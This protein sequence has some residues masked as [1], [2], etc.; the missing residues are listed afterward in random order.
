MSTLQT[1]LVFGG[2]VKVSVADTVEIVQK[3][4]NLHNMS[5]TATAALGRTL[6]AAV[7]LSSELKGNGEKM[8][9]TVDGKGKLGKIVVAAMAGGFVRGYVE[10]PSVELPLNEKGKLAVGEAVGNDGFITIIKD[11]GLK[12]AYVGKCELVSG[13]IAE[14][15]TAYLYKS[16]QRPAAV[17]LGV[18]VDDEVVRAAGGIVVEIMPDC[19]DQVITVCEDIVTNFGNISQLLH[20]KTPKEILEYYFGHFEIE[21][22]EPT[23][24]EYKC[25]CSRDRA[26][27]IILSIGKDECDKYL[28][29]DGKIEICCDFCGSKHEFKKEIVDAIFAR[30]GGKKAE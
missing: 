18:L 11:L 13:E 26:K 14:D 28:A 3:A 4:K 23:I 1:A 24:P 29:E 25:V 9:I 19:P 30:Y 6:T 22:F 21:Y 10:N 12:D 16:E 7:F 17:A 2:N 8:S 27:R 20:E 15:V 5:K